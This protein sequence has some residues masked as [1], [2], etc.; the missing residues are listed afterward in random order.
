MDTETRRKE[1]ID[2]LYETT[3]P[4]S[5]SKLAKKFGVSRQIIVG[6]IA[7]LRAEGNK[8]E[9]TARGYLL[10]KDKKYGYIGVIVA[11]HSC[12]R[13]EEELNTIVDY[14]GTCIDVTVGHAVYGEITGK[15]NIS[16]RYQVKD[17]LNHIDEDA[18]PLSSLSDGVHMHRVGTENKEI[19][20]MIKAELDSKGIIYK[21]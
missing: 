19:F 15:I 2:I 1:I 14:G 8:I 18:L 12:N 17:F 7:L 3:S 13:I 16:S 9:A 5:A 4:V 11:N 6:D 10:S 21:D 20:E